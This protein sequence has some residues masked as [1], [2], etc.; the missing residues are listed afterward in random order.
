MQLALVATVGEIIRGSI[1]NVYTVYTHTHRHGESRDGGREIS[2]RDELPQWESLIRRGSAVYIGTKSID[3]TIEKA[4]TK[5]CSVGIHTEE[6]VEAT[7]CGEKDYTHGVGYNIIEGRERE[8]ERGVRIL[9]ILRAKLDSS[10]HSHC[11]WC[12]L[13][14]NSS[15]ARNLFRTAWDN[16]LLLLLLLLLNTTVLLL[17]LL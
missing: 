15:L 7:C 3:V 11:L 9:Y 10:R 12:P 13:S 17:L 5:L 16:M 2:F 4:A 1:E 6:E 8:R 14:P